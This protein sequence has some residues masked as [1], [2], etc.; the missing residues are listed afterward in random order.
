[1][2]NKFFITLFTIIAITP[3]SLAEENNKEINTSTINNTKKVA[4]KGY[5]TVNYFTNNTASQGTADFSSEWK[6]AIWLFT[7]QQNKDLFDAS[8]DK[9]APQYGGYCAYGI[10]VPEK[11][12]DID[13]KAWHIDNG[14]LYLNYTIRTQNRWLENKSELISDAD[15]VWPKIKNN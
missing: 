8:P 2:L 11:K 1:M 14:K 7:S 3:P 12:V 6:N 5:D 15:K 4:I 10:A 9:Y 13:P